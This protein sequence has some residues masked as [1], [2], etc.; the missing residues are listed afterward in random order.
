MMGREKPPQ[1]SLFYHRINLEQRVREN[2]LLRKIDAAIDFDFMYE[3]VAHTYG[4]NGNE[5]IP[6]PVILKLMLLLMIYNVRSEREL[7]E[8]LPERIDWLWFLRLDLDSDIPDH[9]VLSKAR[10]RWGVEAFR[11]LFERTV[12][13]CVAARLV[14]GRKLFCD[15]SLVEA[16]AS[17]GS[18]VDRGSLRRH[19]NRAYKEMER[20]LEAEEEERRKAAGPQALDERD[21]DEDH[22]DPKPERRNEINKRHIST[23]DPDADLVRKGKGAAKLVHQS[24]RAID[25]ACGVITATILGPGDENEAHRL[26][27]LLDQHAETTGSVATTAVADSKYGTN[28]NLMLC[29]DRGVTL[30][31]RPLKEVQQDRTENR[32]IYPEDRFIYER[33][34]DTYVCPAGERLYKRNHSVTRAASEYLTRRGV[35]ATC[36]VRE[37]CTRAKL[38]RSIKRHDRQDVIDVMRR[39]TETNACRSDLKRRQHFMEGSFGQATRYGFKR[40]RYRRQ[41]RVAIQDLLIAAVQNI[42]ILR[43][44]GQPHPAIALE[45]SLASSFAA[46]RPVAALTS[47]FR[48]IADHFRQVLASILPRGPD[49]FPPAP[50][51]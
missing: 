35:C 31:T 15:S 50:V 38:G 25:S 51:R 2:H 43:R 22:D 19:V 13:D 42:D 29:H 16:N 33:E 18:I 26:T 49:P 7:M 14:N 12:R 9:S 30:H 40:A 32:G 45:A 27:E 6:P 37:E 21:E 11:A 23:T 44:Y 3:E 8:T 24:H 39:A 34:T 10:A 1:P 46:N 20:R 36:A 5:S 41:W 17:M 28:E 47:C 48:F 4:S